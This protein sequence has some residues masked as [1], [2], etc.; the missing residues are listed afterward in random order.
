MQFFRETDEEIQQRKEL[1]SKTVT[2]VS[3]EEMEIDID[4]YF[5][6][7]LDFPKRPVWDHETTKQELDMQ[8]NRYFRVRC[9]FEYSVHTKKNIM[10]EV[11]CYRIAIPVRN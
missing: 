8:E 6:P 5:L 11:L 9:V 1:A 2:P 3:E 4:D 7:E 10:G